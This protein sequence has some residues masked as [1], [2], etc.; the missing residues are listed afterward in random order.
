MRPC[1]IARRVTA[2]ANGQITIDEILAAVDRAL[3]GC[4]QEAQ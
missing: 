4:P 2:V 1:R 3:N